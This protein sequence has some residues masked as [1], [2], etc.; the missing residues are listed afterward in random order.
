[1]TRHDLKDRLFW[2]A[3]E[4][5]VKSS[6]TT[7][8]Y[9]MNTKSVLDKQ[10][11]DSEVVMEV[12]VRELPY[13][14]IWGVLTGVYEVAKL[15]EG[16]P[17]D[18]WSLD[19]GSIFLADG[20]TAMYEPLMII[21]G[22]YRDFVEYENP[23]LGLLSSSTSVSTRAARFRLAA[24]DRTLMSFGTRR[25]HPAL[26]PLVERA[27]YIA[28][29][30]AVSNILGA[31]MLGIKPVGTMPHALMQIVGDQEKAWKMFD[32]II[33]KKIPRIALID[34]F[35]DEK[36]EAI[37][38]LEVFGQ[39]LDAVRL[40]TPSSRRGDFRKIIEE[41]RWELNIRG[42][43][44]VKIMISGR[45]SED[46]VK[47]LRD[48]VD[49]F[50]VGTAVSYPPVIDFSAKIVEVTEGGKKVFRAKRGGLGGRKALYRSKGFHDTVTLDGDSPPEGSVALL[51]PLLRRGEIVHDFEGVESIR[52]R[53]LRELRVLSEAQ[54]RLSWK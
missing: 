12:F 47:Q 41:V 50:G 7:D 8:I 51:K 35:W 21:T 13:A 3:T 14:E 31:K 37:K 18:V 24:G 25:V 36:V 2:L 5:E 11:I 15:L 54:P 33:P 45:L 43:R 53:V 26:A 40:D 34:T 20:S 27:C 48:S 49:G 6:K 4:S 19:E 32:K 39:H 17:V 44:K 23:L 38:A 1:M 16:L 10:H 42:G 9:F 30:D 28:G 46:N 52:R 22:R 29:F